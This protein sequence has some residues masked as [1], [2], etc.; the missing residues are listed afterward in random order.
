M[1][2]PS[3]LLSRRC[4]IRPPAL[5][6]LLPCTLQFFLLHEHSGFPSKLY[7]LPATCARMTHTCMEPAASSPGGATGE[8]FV[9]AS[10]FGHRENILE[11]VQRFQRV[12]GQK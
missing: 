8:G 7:G 11:A 5:Q 4:P 1:L 10:A 3:L 12:Y 2:R 6:W 9:R